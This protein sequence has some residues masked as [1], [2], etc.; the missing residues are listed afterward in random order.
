MSAKKTW[1]KHIS[2]PEENPW[3]DWIASGL[4]KY[5]GRIYRDDWSNM[6]NGDIILFYNGNKKLYTRIISVKRYQNFK[7][8]FEDLRNDLV[9]TP[10]CTAEMVQELYSKICDTEKDKNDIKKFGVVAI[11]ITPL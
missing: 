3:M 8:M 5:E 4:K 6:K 1:N 7:S 11:E 9:P 10:N 2:N